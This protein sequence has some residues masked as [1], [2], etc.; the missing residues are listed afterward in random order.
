MIFKHLSLLYSFSLYNLL[1]IKFLKG[2]EIRELH[3][4]LSQLKAS[5]FQ[6]QVQLQSILSIPPPL[7]ALI[8]ILLNYKNLTV[9]EKLFFFVTILHISSTNWNIFCVS[10]AIFLPHC[11]MAMPWGWEEEEKGYPLPALSPFKDLYCFF[12]PP[13]SFLQKLCFYLSTLPP[14]SF[15]LNKI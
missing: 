5:C 15:F 1:V 8:P 9:K 11:T 13:I 12:V 6:L 3:E 2:A 14:P 7:L 10:K 4:H